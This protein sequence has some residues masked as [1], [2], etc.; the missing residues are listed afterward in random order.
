MGE[1]KHN[2]TAIAARN[3]ALSPKQKPMPNGKKVL[4]ITKEYIERE[5]A[6]E[7]AKH[8]LAKMD[9]EEEP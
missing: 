4:T 3:G 6:I 5:A 8:A 7:A 2:L 1:H 9:K